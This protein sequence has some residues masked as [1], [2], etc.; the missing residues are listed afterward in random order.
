MGKRRKRHTAEE[1]AAILRRHLVDRIPVSDLCDEYGI[2]PTIFY[3]WQKAMFENLPTVFEKGRD[4]EI[5]ALKSKNE[6]L[7]KKLAGKDRVIAQITEEYIEVKKT[8][9]DD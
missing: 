6:A 3:R 4:S 1:K 5:A 2:H 8:P 9:G 7:R